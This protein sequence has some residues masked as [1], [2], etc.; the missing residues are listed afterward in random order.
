MDKHIVVANTRRL[1]AH[2]ALA[3]AT[4]DGQ[5]VTTG[6]VKAQQLSTPRIWKTSNGSELVG[7]PGDWLVES[8]EDSWTV[9]KDVFLAT[10][11]EQ[12]PG[13]YRKTAPVHATRLRDD[14]IV[15]TLEGDA[16]AKAGDW[17]VA[18]SSGDCWPVTHADFTA[19]YRRFQPGETNQ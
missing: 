14:A 18:N 10:Y 2:A 7:R 17:L 19:R 6:V 11:A 16:L 8:G 3:E 12:S 9:Q 5:F 13:V 4:Q 15:Q 1:N